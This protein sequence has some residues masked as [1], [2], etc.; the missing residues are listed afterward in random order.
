MRTATSSIP[1]ASVNTGRVEL[2][3][4][5]HP[6]LPATIG[7]QDEIVR[8]QI[9]VG[10]A[11]HSVRPGASGSPMRLQTRMTIL[12][13]FG[14]R[15]FHRHPRSHVCLG[16]PSTGSTLPSTALGS[17]G[18]RAG[19]R[20]LQTG[21]SSRGISRRPRLPRILLDIGYDLDYEYIKDFLPHGIRV[22]TD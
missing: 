8:A 9:A 2:I 17:G 12:R 10:G 1:S 3:T 21:L 18:L 4:Q 13:E 20:D 19:H 16:A 14:L 22:D 6:R 15:Y 11:F 7:L 5:R